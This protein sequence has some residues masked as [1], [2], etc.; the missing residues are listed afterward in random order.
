MVDV[1]ESEVEGLLTRVR[2]R[3]IM[4]LRSTNWGLGLGF[5]FEGKE[6]K[7]G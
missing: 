6:R 1:D 3:W 2:K 4:P 7:R 5:E